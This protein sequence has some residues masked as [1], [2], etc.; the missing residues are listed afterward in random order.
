IIDEAYR[1]YITNREYP[2]SFKFLRNGKNV[3]ILRTF[4]K[5]YGLA[6]L[7]IGYGIAQP[8]IISNLMKVRMPF[9]VNRLGQIAAL[10]ALEDHNHVRRSRRI[11]EEGKKYLYREFKKLKI[12]FLE[13]WANFVFVNFATD[14][15]EIFEELKKRGVITRTIREYGFPNALRITVGTMSEN[16]RLISALQEILAK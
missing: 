11:N 10:A 9:N 3:L 1:E 12:F 13:S 6:G 16:R 8:E 15:Q 4:S 7:R 2:D 14:A 5:I